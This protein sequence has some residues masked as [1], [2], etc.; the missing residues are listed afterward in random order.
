MAQDSERAP[1]W[2]L[3]SLEQEQRAPDSNLCAVSW[4]TLLQSMSA[5]SQA[6]L[7]YNIESLVLI[8]L[9]IFSRNAGWYKTERGDYMHSS[10]I[11]FDTCGKCPQAPASCLPF[12]LV[13]HAH[14]SIDY[15]DF[16]TGLPLCENAPSCG[17]TSA[18]RPSS[19]S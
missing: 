2:M 14:R 18:T 3:Q 4:P 13:T 19:D 9:L 10:L 6:R 17:V 15:L 8:Q 5:A 1:A 7:L 12:A 16:R 11:N